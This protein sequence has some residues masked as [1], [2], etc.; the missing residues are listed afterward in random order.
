M[1]DLKCKYCGGNIADIGK[2][3]GK[4]DSCGSLLAM[5][6]LNEK[7]S[8]ELYNRADHLRRIH[9]YDGA[10]SAYEHIVA[11]NPSDAEA[12][13]NLVLCKY[14][15]EYTYDGRTSTYLPTI[16][17]MSLDSILEDRDYLKALEYSEGEAKEEYRRQA[18]KLAAIQ[19]ELEKIV[20]E[21]ENYDVFISFKATDEN[22]KRTRDYFLAQEIYDALSTAGLRVFFS[23]V[24]LRSHVGEVY[25]PYIFAA[26]YSAKVMVLVGTKREYLDSEWVKNEWSRYLFMVRQEEK[27]HILPVCEGMK[28]EE[29]PAEI[30][31]MQAVSMNVVGALELVKERV[32]GYTGEKEKR[33]YVKTADGEKRDLTN[34]LRRLQFAVEDGDFEDAANLLETLRREAGEKL[35]EIEYQALFVKYQAKDETELAH[36]CNELTEDVDYHWLLENGKEEQ[37]ELL[38]GLKKR[39][40]LMQRRVFEEEFLIRLSEWYQDGNYAEIVE[41]VEKEQKNG[42]VFEQGGEIDEFYHRASQKCNAERLLASYKAKVGD[43]TAYFENRLREEYPGMAEALPCLDVKEEALRLPLTAKIAGCGGIAGLIMLA[44]WFVFKHKLMTPVFIFNIVLYV[45][46]FLKRC[47]DEERYGERHVAKPRIILKSIPTLA[48]MMAFMFIAPDYLFPYVPGAQGFFWGYW[49]RWFGN[50][51]TDDGIMVCLYIVPL[52]YMI[53]WGFRVMAA[54]RAYKKDVRKKLERKKQLID[55][56]KNFER[57]EEILLMEEYSGI[58]ESERVPLV[59]LYKRAVK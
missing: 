26:L 11:E 31:K 18:L 48:V 35:P 28:P 45:I 54:N 30:G 13:W 14:G 52:F 24:S 9:D 29:F 15:V 58:D 10:I 33:I 7:L 5:P 40:E 21:N 25:E 55:L 19:D 56:L 3:M 38:I 51:T 37:K 59:S 43:G 1:N 36:C 50:G 34:Q 53:L 23:P 39:Q 22:R 32:A 2:G 46:Y 42:M 4:C 44:A 8:G 49:G 57:Q 12:R 47:F 27:K 16:N 17:R 20:R 41:A 6:K